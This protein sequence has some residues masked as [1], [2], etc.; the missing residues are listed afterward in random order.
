MQ[1]SRLLASVILI[2]IASLNITAALA[3]DPQDA[4]DEI[5]IGAASDKLWPTLKESYFA[6][7][8]IVE[9]PVVKLEAPRRAESGAQV[10]VTFSVN[11]NL[12]DGNAIRKVYLF[13]DANPIPL[14]AI[15]NFTPLSGKAQVST[16][17]RMETDSY[18]RVI[19]EAPD[20][21]FYMDSLVIRASGGCAGPPAGGDP[22]VLRLSAGKIKMN[23]E[24]PAKYGEANPATFM[25]KHPQLTGLQRDLV[26]GGY[27]PAFF[28]QKVEFSYNGKPVMQADTTIA[29]AEDPYLRFF[30]LPDGPGTLNVTV[31][32]NEGHTYTH[33]VEV[34]G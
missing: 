18:V 29:M 7:K 17:I 14:V 15:Y 20:G 22:N 10:P 21:K 1:T 12:S 25:I 2:S 24:S 6:G 32:D 34:K 27:I 5:Y 19:G 26:S 23:V 3:V 28:V 30:Y 31:S 11:N 4:K 16:R 8:T 13:V 9:N 33:Q